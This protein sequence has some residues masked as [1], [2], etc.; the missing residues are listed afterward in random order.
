MEGAPARTRIRVAAARLERAIPWIALPAAALGLCL[1]LRSQRAGA[2]ALA[3]LG[4]SAIA[5]SA[6]AFALAPLAQGLSSWLVLRHLTGRTPL[7]PAM[8]VWSRSYVVRY[9]PTGTLA[10]AYRV[11]QRRRVGASTDQVLAAFAYEHVAV[12]AAASALVLVLVPL[13]GAL[14][15]LLP[16]AIALATLALT[17]ALRPGVAGRAVEAV[18]GRLGVPLA[19]VLRGRRLAAVVTVNALGWLGTGAAVY[20][21][22]A[23]MT[24]EQPSFIWLVGSY[25]AAY[26]VGFAAPLA[27]GG[28]G[29]REG[30]LV[31]LLGPTYGTGVALAISLAIRLAN[32]AGELL[33]F[34]LVHALQAA[35]ASYTRLA[36]ITVEHPAPGLAS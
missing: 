8:V 1:V 25:T 29:V 9:A 32:V 10:V 30:M 4:W 27:P 21:L 16:S 7:L 28:L 17:A 23:A 15:P 22:A 26:L 11:S 5:P 2:E 12:L 34:A 33:A 19:I 35:H 3:G 36:R 20:L 6:L 18:S 13:A 24:G 14:P 31:V